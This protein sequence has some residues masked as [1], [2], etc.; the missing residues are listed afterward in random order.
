MS[1]VDDIFGEQTGQLAVLY[2][3]VNQSDAEVPPASDFALGR[4]FQPARELAADFGGREATTTAGGW[5]A[6]FNSTVEA[7]VCARTL[8]SLVGSRRP[9]GPSLSGGLSA[10]EVTREGFGLGGRPIREAIALCHRAQPRQ[11]LVADPL[12][13][14][15]APHSLPSFAPAP[16]RLDGGRRAAGA[17]WED[18]SEPEPPGGP[19]TLRLLV[20]GPGRSRAPAP[21][22]DPALGK[23]GGVRLA[24]LGWVRLEVGEP[25]VPRAVMRGSQARAV[26]SMLALRH[27][28][29]HKDELA[30]LLWPKALPG[31]WEG[32]LR[33]VITKIRRFLDSGG[34]SARQVLI[35]EGGHYELRLPPGV[36]ID[37]DQADFLIVSARAALAHRRPEEAAALSRRAVKILQRRLLSGPDNAWFDQIRAELANERLSALE[38]CAQAELAAGILEGAKQAASEALTQDRYRESS[39][40]LLMQAHAA[41]GSRGEALRTYERCRRLLAEELGV[42]PAAPTQALY[43]QLLG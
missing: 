32:A 43:L 19:P 14:V 38:L 39:Y 42:G 5:L 29:V 33:G 1:L 12:Q 8:A 18:D 7:L 20:T 36:S 16:S 28:P 24:I 41:A 27:G 15:V 11:V 9:G 10:G 4:Y 2:C 34:L 6:T 25:A 37:R 3:E 22:P 23:V 30:E 35:G 17:N 26:L 40:R 21:P 13:V 31:H